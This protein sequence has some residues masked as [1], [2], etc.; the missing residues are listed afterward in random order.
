[1]V[2]SNIHVDMTSSYRERGLNSDLSLRGARIVPGR[3]TRV[4][5]SLMD[6]SAQQDGEVPPSFQ[7]A[8]DSARKQPG[9]IIR[10]MR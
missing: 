9:G 6:W 10:A 7:A 3:E 8:C 5:L 2:V 4:F 1:M